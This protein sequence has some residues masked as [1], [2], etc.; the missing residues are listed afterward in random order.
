MERRQYNKRRSK[1][2]NYVLPEY[3]DKLVTLKLSQ[4]EIDLIDQL[5]ENRSLKS[6]HSRADVIMLA[7]KF[8]L[9]QLTLIDLKL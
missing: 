3:R 4:K 8:S 1:L 5:K 6:Y 2:G 9:G 7:V